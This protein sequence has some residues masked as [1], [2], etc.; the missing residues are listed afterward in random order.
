MTVFISKDNKKIIRLLTKLLVIYSRSIRRI[1]LKYFFRYYKNV[2]LLKY[3][4]YKE[5]NSNS[6]KSNLIFNKSFSNS[7]NTTISTNHE[8]LNIAPYSYSLSKSQPFI[9]SPLLNK[10]NIAFLMT[11]CYFLDSDEINYKNTNKVKN[12]FPIKEN[13]LSSPK[14]KKIFYRTNSEASN[15]N[16][17]YITFMN[18]SKRKNFY[19]NKNT[20]KDSERNNIYYPPEDQNSLFNRKLNHLQNTGNKAIKIIR[21]ISSENYNKKRILFDRDSVEKYLNKNKDNSNYYG[22]KIKKKG[23]LNTIDNDLFTLEEEK[24]SLK[25]NKSNN[26]LKINNRNLIFPKNNKK[27]SKRSNFNREILNH[28]YNN[29]Y[30]KPNLRKQEL[31]IENN[32]NKNSNNDNKK[33]KKNLL[34]INTERKK[35]NNYP[36]FN[37]NSEIGKVNKKARDYLFPNNQS[38][39]EDP[40]NKLFKKNMMTIS[41]NYFKINSKTKNSFFGLEPNKVN[42]STSMVNNS[43]NSNTQS[44]N[45]GINRVSTNYTIG[46]YGQL[47]KD[48]NKIIDNKSSDNKKSSYNN[49]ENKKKI[50]NSKS[51]MPL[52][53]S[54]NINDYYRKSFSRKSDSNSNRISLQSLN[55]S[56]MLELAGH[57]GNEEDSSSDN[58]KMNTIIHYKKEFNGNINKNNFI[59]K[60]NIN[61]KKK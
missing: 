60:K 40:Y 29:N 16:P 46:P 35:K 27:K 45:A 11:P 21:P 59:R 53:I 7:K 39:Y 55:D 58:Y 5:L 36:I 17:F 61:K 42:K 18:D 15:N 2:I 32:N 34:L 38:N 52:K 50:N 23:A 47:I 37:K 10:K 12:D 9:F 54:S 24:N 22:N 43:N 33:K 1:K 26:L 14:K 31:D 48:Q 41:S 28:L 3:L 25:R 51:Q 56:K 8:S 13:Y 44:I 19:T 49:N 30:M 20:G 57:Y 6:K 4:K